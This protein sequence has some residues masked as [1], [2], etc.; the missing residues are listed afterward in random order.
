MTRDQSR[1]EI[2]RLLA[3]TSE[4]RDLAW[5]A[6]RTQEMARDAPPPANATDDTILQGAWNF[7]QRTWVANIDLDRKMAFLNSL[8]NL[9]VE[10]QASRA[11]YPV[12]LILLAYASRGQMSDRR[13][14]RIIQELRP[15]LGAVVEMLRAE[16]I[17][18]TWANFGHLVNDGTIEGVLTRWAGFLP[19]SAIRLRVALDQASGSGLTSLDVIAR[20]IAEHPHFPWYLVKRLYPEEWASARAAMV[21]VGNNRFYGYRADLGGVRSSQ[22]KYLSWVCGR[23]LIEVG[24]DKSL[25]RYKGFVPHKVMESSVKEMIAAYIGSFELPNLKDD[26]EEDEAIDM[27]EML[28]I[29]QGY[30]AVTAPR[31]GPR[32]A[33][34]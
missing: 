30:P 15:S 26:R 31:P 27:M 17:S 18:M 4:L 24:G 32:N 11:L 29:A 10:R 12:L 2:A 22:F 3:N 21:T 20:A 1:E 9:T 14:Q 25:V 34:E 5:F 33:E 6:D 8:A 16:D 13:L 23:I 7:T 28:S 19:T